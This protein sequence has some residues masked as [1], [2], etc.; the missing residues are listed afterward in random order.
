MADKIEQTIELLLEEGNRKGYLSYSE[1]NGFLEDR[2]VPPE[3]MDQLFL[4]FEEQGIEVV[5]DPGEEQAAIPG[6]S[7]STPAATPAVKVGQNRSRT[8]PATAVLER[9]VTPERIDDPVRMYLT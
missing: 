3:R 7:Q 6:R 1:I 9:V 8:Q 2:F 4:T 5:D